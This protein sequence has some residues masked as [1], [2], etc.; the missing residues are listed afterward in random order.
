MTVYRI[1]LTNVPQRF[2]IELGG[3]EYVMVVRWNPIMGNWVMCLLDGDMVLV[4]CLPLVTGVDLL[5]QFRHLGINGSFVV[6]TDGDPYATPTLGNL[7][8]DSNLYYITGQ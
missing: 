2:A 7:G 6:V 3:R 8:T 5:A 4:N 1:P